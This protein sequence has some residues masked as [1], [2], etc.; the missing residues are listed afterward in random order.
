VKK[1]NLDAA[2]NLDVA[3]GTAKVGFC[4]T[5]AH[6]AAVSC[7]KPGQGAA[8]GKRSHQP[9]QALHETGRHTGW[10]R[11]TRPGGFALGWHQGTGVVQSYSSHAA[12]GSSGSDSAAGPEGDQDQ[13][14]TLPCRPARPAV[15]RPHR[16]SSALLGGGFAPRLGRHAREHGS[17]Y[18]GLHQ[19][20]LCGSRKVFSEG[21]GACHR[22]LYD[23][24]RRRADLLPRRRAEGRRQADE[25]FTSLYRPPGA[26]PGRRRPTI[27]WRRLRPRAATWR[28]RWNWWTGRSI[29]MR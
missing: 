8:R 23:A 16:G 27:R 19:G 10:D 4:A 24:Q 17:R 7:S 22:P 9:R 15:S 29:P 28:R 2:V 25:A 3:A 1:A 20:P 26:R 14:G 5:S 18:R 12:T 11:R 21:P 13:R 6:S